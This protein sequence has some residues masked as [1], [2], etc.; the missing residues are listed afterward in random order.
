M[1]I[2]KVQKNCFNNLNKNLLICILIIIICG[3]VFIIT[4]TVLENYTNYKKNKESITNISSNNSSKPVLAIH[5]VFIL[6]EN[7]IFL[8]EWIT[9][10]IELGFSQF[11]FYDN[12]GSIGRSES[13]LHKTRMGLEFNKMFDVNNIYLEF[14]KLEKKYPQI[15]YI[16]WQPKNKKNEIIYA[17]D[18]AIA[19]YRDN[20]SK[21]SD[22]TAFIDPDE[23][24]VLNDTNSINLKKYI[25]DK[26][27]KQ[28]NIILMKQKKFEDRFCNINNYIFNIN[29]IITKI[30]V[31]GWAYKCLYKNSE[32]DPNETNFVVHKISMKN[33]NKTHTASLNELRFNHYNAN[34]K[35]INWMKGFFKKD[36]FEN[37]KDTTM[38]KFNYLINKYNI[39]KH[40][41]NKGY[42]NLVKKEICY[43]FK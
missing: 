3:L 6:P 38:K 39:P 20:Y 8:E 18:K 19:H 1:N 14:N 35:Q 7:F 10:H 2:I 32:I 42:Y 28:I 33:N 17:P 27:L 25:K 24:I 31:N 40:K 29:N 36:K 9:Y 13:T 15:K 22:W 23:F 43:N 30:N 12:Y 26:E 34:N 11:Y 4:K 21:N 37:D 41:Y 5:S 16:K